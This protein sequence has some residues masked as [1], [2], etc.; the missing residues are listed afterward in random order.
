MTEKIS[1]LPRIKGSPEVA[2]LLQN[3]MQLELAKGVPSRMEPLLE[4][5]KIKVR[6]TMD[7]I[8]SRGNDIFIAGPDWCRENSDMAGAAHA[9]VIVNAYGSTY[10]LPNKDPIAN[11]KALDSGE[12][13]MFLMIDEKENKPIGTACMVLDG[14]WAE[15]GRAA[16]LGHVGNSLIQDLRILHWLT[17]EKFS[18][19]FHSLFA[20]LRTAPDRNIG[21]DDLPEIMRGGQAVSHIWANMPNVIVGGF[22][23]LYKKHGAL[24]QFTFAFITQKELFSPGNLWVADPVDLKFVESWLKQHGLPVGKNN[25]G[26]NISGELPVNISFP[27]PESG[28][29]E[30]VHGEMKIGKATDLRF[31]EAIT[32]LMDAGVPFIQFPVPINK[33]TVSLQKKL[34]EWGFQAFQFTPG[35]KD[36][37]DP[38][39]WFGHKAPWVDEVVPT[40]WQKDPSTSNPFWNDELAS[41]ADRIFEDWKGKT[42]HGGY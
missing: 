37:Q 40:F 25:Q 6:E 42:V 30:F 33:D 38:E 21:T 31:E 11:K 10:A 14:G 9:E 26:I 20:T 39:L 23:P 18:K 34:K 12:L 5:L 35:L 15:L 2:A 17:D 28:I 41:H 8:N 16:S 24:E 1:I 19:R 27:P 36:V 32:T 3:P 22:G 29:T 13:E 4:H 7:T